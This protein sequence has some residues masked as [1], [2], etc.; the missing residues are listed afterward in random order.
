MNNEHPKVTIRDVAAAAGVTASTVSRAFARPGR[1]NSATAARIQR[2]ADSMGYHTTSITRF[3]PSDRFNGLIAIVVADL[4]NPV[5]AE[6]TRSA[7]HECM[8]HDLGLLVIDSEENMLIE[9]NAIHLATRHI[10][11]IILA[12]SR[13]SDAGIRKLAQMKPIV[14]INRSIRGVQSVLADTTKGLTRAVDHLLELGHHDISY[15]GGPES[16][17]QE[18]VRWRTVSSLCSARSI[19]PRRIMSTAPTFSGGYRC[20]TQFLEHRT[21]AVIAYNDIMA[22][23]FIAALHA[24]G[25]RVPQEVSVVGI[26]DVQFSSLVSPALS[27]VR[28]PRKELGAGAVD[29]MNA[30]LHHTNK[31]ECLKPVVLDS[32]FVVRASTGRAYAVAKPE[33]LRAASSVHALPPCDNDARIETTTPRSVHRTP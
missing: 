2:I 11:G 26:D 31:P 30:I 17:W 12:S 27:T 10:D 9:R 3:D 29:E 8:E 14:A 5:F 24:Q 25:I 19:R 18:G 16:S 23:G 21:S 22:I 20:R 7:Q 4:S 6:Y 33:R 28:L 32:T 13:L 15:L 1:V